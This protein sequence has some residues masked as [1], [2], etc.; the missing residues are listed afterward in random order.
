MLEYSF[1]IFGCY[2]NGLFFSEFL[3]VHS[4]HAEWHL[5]HLLLTEKVLPL[6]PALTLNPKAQYVFGLTK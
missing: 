3:M 2:E 4:I 1:L 5:L 6:T